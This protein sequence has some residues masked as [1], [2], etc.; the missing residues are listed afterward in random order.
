[1]ASKVKDYPCNCEYQI[2]W[3]FDKP[4]IV[5][6]ENCERTLYY[7]YQQCPVCKQEVTYFVKEESW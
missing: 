3:H 2:V 7:D 4:T 6:C 1:M 5:V